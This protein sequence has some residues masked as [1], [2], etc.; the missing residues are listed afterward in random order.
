M[1]AKDIQRRIIYDRYQRNFVMPNFT[2]PGWFECDVFELTKAGFFI[3]YEIKISF[4]DF[5]ADAFKAKELWEMGVRWGERKLGMSKHDQIRTGQ[6]GSPSK[7]YFVCP[8]N[9]ATVLHNDSNYPSWAGLIACHVSERHAGQTHPRSIVT[10]VLRDAP[11]LHRV[12][13]DETI[14]AKAHVTCYWRMHN[15]MLYGRHIQPTET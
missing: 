6:P 9:L 8:A 11:R 13:Y 12:K 14:K 15:L 3:E 5:K 4:S 10:A 1:T 2:P 7:F